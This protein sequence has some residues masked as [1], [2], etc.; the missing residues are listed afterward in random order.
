MAALGQ[1]TACQIARVTPGGLTQTVE[2]ANC[3]WKLNITSE[4]AIPSLP[5]CALPYGEIWYDGALLFPA[6]CVAQPVGITYSKFDQS[7]Y[8]ATQVNPRHSYVKLL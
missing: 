3:E 8:V 7:L 4:G 6:G 2:P 1:G 5:K